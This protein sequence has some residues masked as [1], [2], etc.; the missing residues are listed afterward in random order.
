MSENLGFGLLSP[1]LPHIFDSVI[2][3]I[4]APQVSNSSDS[5]IVTDTV[6]RF[7]PITEKVLFNWYVALE[8]IAF[9][10]RFQVQTS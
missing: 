4:V 5:I 7:N 1:Q 2:T 3:I 6:L 8:R 10:I 9:F